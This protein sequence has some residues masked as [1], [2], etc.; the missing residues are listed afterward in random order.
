MDVERDRP[1]A[2]ALDR[3]RDEHF[4]LRN[5]GAAPP[6]EAFDGINRFRR[7]EHANAIG[8]VAD[9]RLGTGAGKMNN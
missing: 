8:L 6:D 9:N 3:I 7:F 2:F 1:G 4:L 5:L